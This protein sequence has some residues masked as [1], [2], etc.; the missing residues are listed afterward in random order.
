MNTTGLKKQIKEYIINSIDDAG[1]EAITEN[2]TNKQKLQFIANNFKREAFYTNNLKRF[3][4]NK[5]LVISDHLQGLPSYLNIEFS[6]YNILQ[7]SKKWGFNLDTEKKED[8]FIENYWNRIAQNIIEL[9]R[10]YDISI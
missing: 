2:A 6:N 3:G 4:N 10:K 9:F 1:Y 5:Q 7:L 8:K